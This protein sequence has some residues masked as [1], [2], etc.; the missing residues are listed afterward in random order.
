MLL[1]LV[2][3]SLN[4]QVVIILSSEV[5]SLYFLS[6]G[7]PCIPE[8]LV[9]QVPPIQAQ[10]LVS[11][12]GKLCRYLLC[13]PTNHFLN[14]NSESR[15]QQLLLF[16]LA[17]FFSSIPGHYVPQL[18]K[19]MIEVNKE[20][21]IFNLKGIAVS[22]YVYLSVKL[23]DTL[24]YCLREKWWLELYCS[25]VI[26]FLNMPRTSIQGLSTSGLMD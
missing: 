14:S 13:H 21:K 17:L 19:F 23:I 22:N 24:G 10:G 15:F 6:Q 4:T 12:W 8:T 25:W 9:Q 11:D 20:E 26:H 5:V 16:V 18:A 7:Q 1:I 3:L 2:W